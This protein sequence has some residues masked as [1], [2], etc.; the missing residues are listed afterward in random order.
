MKAIAL[1]LL[2]G[3][4][5]STVVQA[6]TVVSCRKRNP[7]VYTAYT[8]VQIEQDT[9][10]NLT[11]IYGNGMESQMLE[12]YFTS[13]VEKTSAQTYRYQDPNYELS[14]EIKKSKLSFVLS[15]GGKDYKQKNYEC[16]TFVR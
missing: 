13:S 1:T 7:L 4:L 14:V 9:N 2:T 3:M 6:D 11:F 12:V 15:S 8:W 10:Q 16:L 5:I